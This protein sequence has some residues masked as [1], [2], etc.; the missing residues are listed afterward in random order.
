[1]LDRLALA[2][3]LAL[4]IAITYLTLA[5]PGSLP[6]VSGGDKL[7]HALAFAALVFPFVVA[8]PRWALRTFAA[9]IAY[10]GLIELIQPSFG[11]SGEWADLLADTIGAAVG[12]V[13]AWL[14]RWL[15]PISRK[16]A[17]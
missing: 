11:R 2:A 10:G 7:H 4:L 16:T 17:A 1:M 15:L 5:A 8:R 13:L 14:T 3:T 9:A 6:R 12:I